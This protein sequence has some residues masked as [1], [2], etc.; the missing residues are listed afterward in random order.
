MQQVSPNLFRFDDTCAVY[1]V[2]TGKT[3]VLVDFGDGAILDHLQEA[4]VERV[5][6][7]L[8]THHH[9]DQGQGLARAVA[10]DIRIWVP[11]AEQDLFHSVQDHWQARELDNSYNTRE[12][13]FS[14]RANVPVHATLRDYA[15][16]TFGDVE[17]TVVPTPGHTTGSVSLLASVDGSAVAFTGDL[18]YAPGKVWS[19][20]STQWSYNGAEGV[21]ASV[22]SLLD[23]RDRAPDVLLPSHGAPMS[24]PSGAIDLLVRRLRRLLRERKQNPRL[25]EL[26]DRPYERLTPHLLRNRTAMAYHYVLLSKSGKALFIDFGYDF[27]T[28]IAAGYDRASRRPWLYTLPV[29]KR[30]FGVTT[31]DVVVPTHYHDDH[32]AGLNLLRRVEGTAVWAADLFAEVLERPTDFDLPCL[33]YDAIPVD[34]RLPLETPVA[35]EEYELVLHHLP[36][37]THFAVAVE[38]EVDGRKVVATGDQYQGGESPLW[39][40]V[41]QNGFGVGDYVKSAELLGRVRPDLILTGHWDPQWPDD[42]Y[43]AALRRGGKVLDKLHRE[44]LPAER[45]DEGPFGAG[46]PRARILPYRSELT[47]GEER[48]I[49]VRVRN[50]DTCEQTVQVELEVPGGFS[51]SPQ[52]ASQVVPPRSAATLRFTLR[53][54]G[55]ADRRR[56][57]LTADVTLGDQ[58][59][60]QVA[61]AVVRV[62]AEG[63]PRP[64]QP[65]QKT[66]DRT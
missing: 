23:L 29:L 45:L 63:A 31:V 28:G 62:T 11:H 58:R 36:G 18:I 17:I 15:R 30:D 46:G 59:Y 50:P 64:A 34:R 38:F 66:G 32:I 26:R 60:G 19:L 10:Q 22:A 39:N 52:I 40:Y 2:R 8:M 3:G 1:L 56:Q 6:D 42:A 54:D 14:L 7:V 48:E 37:H 41:Y 24:E 47:V 33:W 12:D 51:V 65:H 13:R 44:V 53:A 4:G 27:V 9:V 43:F 5:T 20:A 57:L 35:W 55:P 16:L 25:L 61:E 21:A 49:E